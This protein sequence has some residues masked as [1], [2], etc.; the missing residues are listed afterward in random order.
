MED[1]FSEFS[2]QISDNQPQIIL[3]FEDS[4]LMND[5]RLKNDINTNPY[6]AAGN[7]NI[8]A[9]YR[10]LLDSE[11]PN[12]DQL[13]AEGIGISKVCVFL[14]QTESEFRALI[15]SPGDENTLNGLQTNLLRVSCDYFWAS[16]I[17]KF[18]SPEGILTNRKKDLL[19]SGI[20]EILEAKIIHIGEDLLEPIFIFIRFCLKGSFHLNKLAAGSLPS[21]VHPN[22]DARKRKRIIE[23]MSIGLRKKR[24]FPVSKVKESLQS[25]NPMEVE[26]QLEILSTHVIIERPTRKSAC[27]VRQMSEDAERFLKSECLYNEAELNVLKRKV[28]LLED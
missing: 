18:L 11:A 13:K 21:N 14:K 28:T 5:F 3:K 6:R 17:C 7:F 12:C 25:I 4:P 10:T 8:G 2:S 24:R 26:N 22:A 1:K 9:I 23:R 15:K 27:L 20:D 16:F 19:I